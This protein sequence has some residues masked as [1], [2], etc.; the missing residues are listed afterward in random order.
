M[1]TRAPAVLKNS[2]ALFGPFSTL[3][4]AKTPFLVPEN[5]IFPPIS[6]LCLH[7]LP[8]QMPGCHNLCYPAWLQKLL[9]VLKL[10]EGKEKM[11]FSWLS[12][13]LLLGSIWTRSKA[14]RKKTDR[15][16]WTLASL[17]IQHLGETFQTHSVCLLT[18]KIWKNH[19][20]L[21]LLLFVF[22]WLENMGTDITCTTHKRENIPQ[23]AHFIYYRVI[24]KHH[25]INQPYLPW[26]IWAYLKSKDPYVFRVWV[27]LGFQMFL[28]IV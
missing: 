21:E 16:T 18:L 15:W 5:E 20:L 28:E 11:D 1:T 27:R 17:A 14:R 9:L 22:V 19:V 2:F 12:V 10:R 4:N 8:P 13:G 24:K 25:H 3:F 7:L 6:S 23:H 26:A